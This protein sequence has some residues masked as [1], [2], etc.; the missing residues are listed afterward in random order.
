MTSG[1]REWKEYYSKVGAI[2]IRTQNIKTDQLVLD[3]VA[4]V[5]LPSSREGTRTR[6]LQGDILITITGA[7]VTKA[8]RVED[9]LP[10]AYV[11]QHIALTR[12]RFR[13]MSEWLHLCLVSHGAA[14]GVLE[15]LAYGDKPGLNLNNIRD[16][17]FLVPPL[18]DQR[19]IL[20]KVNQLMHLVDQLEAQLAASRVAGERLVEAL[21]VELTSAQA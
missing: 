8:A 9:Q 7:N 4:Y 6:V 19:R 5:D 1:S 11:S 21:L 17:V 15:K 14:R 2:F 3:D 16:L 20:K 10:E 12:P 13:E 18:A